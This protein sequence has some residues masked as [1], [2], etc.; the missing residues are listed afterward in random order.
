MFAWK[1]KKAVA[2]YG[3]YA[4]GQT[5]SSLGIMRDRENTRE[6]LFQPAHHPPNQSLNEPTI[7]NHPSKAEIF[8]S[9]ET[10][11]AMRN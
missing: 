1:G 7:P 5:L 2:E 6:K 11:A 8:A 9:G 10:R 4:V 3:T